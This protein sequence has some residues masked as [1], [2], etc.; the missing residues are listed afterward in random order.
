MRELWYSPVYGYCGIHI[1][2]RTTTLLRRLLLLLL[3]L[4]LLIGTTPT[5]IA[6]N[7]ISTIDSQSVSSGR[8]M[9]MVYSGTEPID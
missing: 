4:L 1:I 6:S 8:V 3:L 5:T 7:T 2:N 9:T